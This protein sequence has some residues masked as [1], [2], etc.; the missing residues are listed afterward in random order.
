MA[1]N[2][3]DDSAAAAADVPAVSAP[4]AGAAP[5]PADAP[6]GDAAADA[7]SD[8]AKASGADSPT[9]L[10]GQSIATA[11]SAVD[12]VVAAV[13]TFDETYAAGKARAWVTGAVAV[14]STA[15]TNVS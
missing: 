8:E 10:L 5:P 4:N 7:S 14:V 13:T 3:A 11:V 9:T 15:A 2:N 1:D 12:R 6:A